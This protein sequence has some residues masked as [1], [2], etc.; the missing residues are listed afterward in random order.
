MQT[1]MDVDVHINLH[2]ILSMPIVEPLSVTQLITRL[3]CFSTFHGRARHLCD[4]L[5][6]VLSHSAESSILVFTLSGRF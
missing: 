3:I 5:V 4:T 2:C 1:K 6:K